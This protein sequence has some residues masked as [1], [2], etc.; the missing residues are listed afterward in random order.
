MKWK[1]LVAPEIFL[2]FFSSNDKETGGDK[3]LFTSHLSK[4]GFL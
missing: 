3:S 4:K 1:R 2:R